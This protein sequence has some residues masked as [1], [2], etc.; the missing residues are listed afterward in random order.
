MTN[1][2]KNEF[3][4][5]YTVIPGETLEETLDALGISQ[6][7]LAMRIGQPLKMV[8][9]IIKG[10]TAITDDTA[11]QLEKVLNIPASFWLCLE[12]QY[13]E[14]LARLDA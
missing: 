13:C 14:T 9:E 6:H 2:A 12:Q 3:K 1:S 10:K 8:S 7:E 4:P 5:N 11:L